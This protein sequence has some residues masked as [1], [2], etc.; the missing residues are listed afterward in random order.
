MSFEEVVSATLGKN[1]F[2]D[3]EVISLI[4]PYLNFHQLCLVE[5]VSRTFKS[6]VITECKRIKKLNLLL[7]YFNNQESTFLA[8]LAQYC[9]NLGQISNFPSPKFR[10]KFSHYQTNFSKLKNIYYYSQYV[11]NEIDINRFRKIEHLQIIIDCFATCLFLPHG[12]GSID[13]HIN[14]SDFDFDRKSLIDN[15][16][17]IKS[18]NC[19]QWNSKIEEMIEYCPNIENLTVGY[20]GAELL[21]Q[22][23]KIRSLH[24]LIFEFFGQSNQVL[25]TNL[26]NMKSLVKLDI[27]L[28]GGATYANFVDDI[29]ENLQ[30]LQFLSLK[31]SPS[32]IE[33]YGNF[34]KLIF[35]QKLEF[36]NLRCFVNDYSCLKLPKLEKL[37]IL[38]LT[39]T[40]L[41]TKFTDIV[42]YKNLTCLSLSNLAKFDEI[43][44]LLEILGRQLLNL[45][46]SYCLTHFNSFELDRL[47]LYC[48]YLNQLSLYPFKNIDELIKTRPLSINFDHLSIGFYE[49]DDHLLENQVWRLAEFLAKIKNLK[50]F[51]TNKDLASKLNQQS[52]IIKIRKRRKF[53]IDQMMCD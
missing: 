48:P 33:R 21:H 9:P 19:L 27:I 6:H 37:K 40:T 30:D 41:S 16:K 46:L 34:E 36:L 2:F 7:V 20:A 47:M 31:F 35:L 51:S 26:H 29:C 12:I 53:A 23:P 11:N 42:A 1:I 3:E 13:I 10:R 15:G 17:N 8:K 18:I 50:I 49:F 39:D 24:N 4:L 5:R 14:N 32:C 22:L 38:K 43:Q 28:H 45:Y 52:C 25:W 44:I